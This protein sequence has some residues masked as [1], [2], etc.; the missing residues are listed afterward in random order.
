MDSDIHESQK[1]SE[2]IPSLVKP[3][4]GLDINDESY[5]GPDFLGKLFEGKTIN[6]DFRQLKVVKIPSLMYWTVY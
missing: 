3:T 5:T 4:V 2:P 6:N 1:L